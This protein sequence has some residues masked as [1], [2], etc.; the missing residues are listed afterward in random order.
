MDLHMIMPQ[1]CISTA[2]HVRITYMGICILR[3]EELENGEDRAMCPG[4][5]LII[6]VIGDKGQLMCG[7]TTPGPST[8]KLVKC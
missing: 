4:C 3:K 1:R 6:K 8:N 7:E 5:S 2:A